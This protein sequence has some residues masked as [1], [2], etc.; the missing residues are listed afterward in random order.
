MGSRKSAKVTTR[1]QVEFVFGYSVRECVCV[2]L[3]D[4]MS[5]TSGTRAWHRI[6]SVCCDTGCNHMYS[7]LHNNV[8]TPSIVCVCKVIINI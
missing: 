6:A 2:C 4:F 5:T 7:A 3:F 1:T 8:F